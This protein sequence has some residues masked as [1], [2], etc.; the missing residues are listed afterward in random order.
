MGCTSTKMLES[1]PQGLVSCSRHSLWDA[2]QLKCWTS[3]TESGPQGLVSCKMHE[4]TF[5]M[6]CTSTKMHESGP[7]GLVSC[8]RHSLWDALQLKCMSLDLK[9][10]CLVADIHYGMH[11]N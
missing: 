2:L 6:G 5:T 9:D 7:Q 3:R 8:S 4:Q 11:F 1:G 10:W